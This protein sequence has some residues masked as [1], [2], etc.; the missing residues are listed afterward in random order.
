MLIGMTK[1]E[2][3][4]TMYTC[5][6]QMSTVGISNKIVES[7]VGVGCTTKTW[8]ASQEIEGRSERMDGNKKI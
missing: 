5:V 3:L 1:L 7:N 2:Q 4:L 6:L 8:K